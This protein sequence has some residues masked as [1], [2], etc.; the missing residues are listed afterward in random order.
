MAYGTG[1]H[2]PADLPRYLDGIRFP[3]SRMDLI[4]HARQHHADPEMI[5]KLEEIPDDQ[6]DSMDEVVEK[7]SLH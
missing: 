5:E 2:S 4:Q 1:G 3:A 6:Y 7:Y